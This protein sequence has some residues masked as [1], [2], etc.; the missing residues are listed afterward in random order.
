MGGK[1]KIY[2]LVGCPGSGKTWVCSQLGDA[3][4]IVPHDKRRHNAA[5]YAREIE[6]EME[7]ATKPLIIETPFGVSEI[8]FEL[9]VK[10]SYDVVPV[11]IIE[12]PGILEERYF[13]RSGKQ[14]PQ[15][16]LTRQE[17]YRERAR[18]LGA[19]TGTSAEVAAMLKSG[20]VMLADLWGDR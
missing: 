19:F 6:N 5:I 14:I 9:K 20:R 2:L 12:E 17:T 1:Q 11:F 15:G 7:T 10:R 13:K 3:F 16:H 18:D 4:H 8:M